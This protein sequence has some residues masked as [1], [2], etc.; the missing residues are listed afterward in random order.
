MLLGVHSILWT[1]DPGSMSC[2]ALQLGALSLLMQHFHF[3]GPLALL[4]CFLL[5]P[6]QQLFKSPSVDVLS[7]FI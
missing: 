4:L 7:V 5:F 3:Q 2:Q 1:H 6:K